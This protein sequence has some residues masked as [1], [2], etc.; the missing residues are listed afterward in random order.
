MAKQQP[1][2]DQKTFDHTSDEAKS[3]MGAWARERLK[4]DMIKMA[5]VKTRSGRLR[6]PEEVEEEAKK[7][8]Q[9]KGITPPPLSAKAS[10]RHS[11]A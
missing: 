3:M 4:A 6:A 1:A 10:G 8:G 9:A 2:Q 7:K 11:R 5:G